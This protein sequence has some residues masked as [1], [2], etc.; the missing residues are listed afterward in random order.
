MKKITKKILATFAIFIVL[1]LNFS[2]YAYAQEAVEPLVSAPAA[3]QAPAEPKAPAAPSAPELPKAPVSPIVPTTPAF[4]APS[5]TEVEDPTPTPA[6]TP[7]PEAENVNQD[8]TGGQVGGGNT[9][10]DSIIETGDATTDGAITNIGNTNIVASGSGSNLL[11]G[12]SGTV[13]ANDSNGAATT[14]SGVV[15]NNSATTTQQNNSAN[16]VNNLSQNSSTGDNSNSSN[17]G[18]TSTIN[19]GD[20][21][22]SGTILNMVNTNAAGVVVSE[23]NIVDDYTGDYVLD[24]ASNCIAGCIVGDTVLTNTNNGSGSVNTGTIDSNENNATFQNNAVDIENNLV[25]DANTGDNRTDRNT[26]GDSTIQTGNANVAASVGNFANNNF[27]GNVYMGVVNI[28]G[29]LNGDIVLPEIPGCSTCGSSQINAAD[30]GSGDGSDNLTTIN[31][32]DE[33]LLSQNNDANIVNN[34]N[35]DANTG[36]NSTD[37]NTSGNNSIVTGEANLMANVVN[38]ANNNIVG[39]DWWL[40]IVNEAGNWIGKILGSPEG[41]NMAASSGT[42]ISSNPNGEITV[43]NNG[44]GSQS[45]NTGSIN[46]STSNATTQN[47]DANIVNNI[48]LG[49]NTG[50]NSASRNTGGDNSITTGDANIILNIINFVN[51]NVAG[52]GRLFVTL[53]NVFGSWDGDFVTPGQENPDNGNQEEQGNG[54]GGVA[55]LPP[56]N[57]NSQSSNSSSDSGNSNSSSSSGS[58]ATVLGASTTANKYRFGRSNANGQLASGVTDQKPSLV[59]EAKAADD[60]NANR[61]NINLAWG[62]LL[63]PLYVVVRL[64]RRRFAA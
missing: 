15:N 17:T 61:V 54:T 35:I 40:V 8:T 23:F 2:R 7:T 48:D 62:L 51:N 18:G 34:V 19:T 58:Q 31:N 16:I 13:L 60:N 52:N 38:I 21:N 29:D 36:E 33:Y 28:Y 45:H 37:R 47:N 9:G 30:S 5:G 53:V 39:G 11:P 42:E 14:N 56:T 44:N 3:P 6:P 25:L 24:F 4:P 20:A 55:N 32:T 57:S 12:G 46:Q 64:L 41:T 43:S 50:N 26:G 22:T 27:A 59:A 49:A 10:V 1:S 63:L